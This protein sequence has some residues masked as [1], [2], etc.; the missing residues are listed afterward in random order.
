MTDRAI[1]P[2]LIQLLRWVATETG[3]RNVPMKRVTEL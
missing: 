3:S 2:I 1:L